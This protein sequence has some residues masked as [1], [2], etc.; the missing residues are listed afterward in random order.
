MAKVRIYELAK[1]RGVSANYLVD[2]LREQ[3]VKVKSTLSTVDE[4]VLKVLD[5]AAEKEA[6]EEVQKKDGSGEDRFVT[7]LSAQE[8]PRQTEGHVV[9]RVAKPLT[10]LQ[11]EAAAHKI[12]PAKAPA[13]PPKVE[14]AQA[15]ESAEQAAAAEAEET[16]KRSAAARELPSRL[17]EPIAAEG[18]VP[19]VVKPPARRRKADAKAEEPA[20][21]EAPAKETPAK[22]AAPPA[23][24]APA[25]DAGKAASPKKTA[26]K[27][28]PAKA[29]E[30]AG[31]PKKA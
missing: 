3:G 15:D 4:D 10:Q 19:R 6:Q 28:A 21:P 26:A 8:A 22:A 16:G 7:V 11:E 31:A 27:A 14:P 29:P 30:E 23:S 13:P 9:Y 17:P 25:G 24:G 18:P 12:Q 20:K 2:A 1:S 5:K